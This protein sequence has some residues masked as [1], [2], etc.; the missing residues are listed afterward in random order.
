MT[1][2]AQDIDYAP[3]HDPLTPADIAQYAEK[4]EKPGNKL[5]KVVVWAVI[6]G[7]F[8][9]ISISLGGAIGSAS[10]PLVGVLASLGLFALT[11]ALAWFAYK[12]ETQ[13]I[14]NQRARSYKFALRNNAIYTPESTYIESQTGMIFDNGDKGPLTDIFQLTVKDVSVEIGNYVYSTGS[15]KSRREHR[16]GYMRL[17][18]QR[19]LPHMVLDSKANNLTAFGLTLSNGLGE[20]FKHDQVLS[21]EGD[22][23]NYFT[24]YCPK[25]YER[26]ALYVFTPDLMALLIDEAAS[27]D[28]EIVDNDMYVYQNQHFPVND[29]AAFRRLVQIAEVVGTKADDRTDYYAD[30]RVGDRSQDVVAIPGK[31]L[32]QSIPWITFIAI[33][34]YILWHFIALLGA[35][36]PSP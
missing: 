16:Y 1:H 14:T 5:V 23:N 22:F 32:K 26:D 34:L 18:L 21:L 11:A 30:E 3:L 17:T 13:K 7:I 8:G 28:V 29:E 36:N 6:F 20:R 35:G 15:G 24:L 2:T 4:F 27:F 9:F 31:R 25:Q 19:H 12:Y 10:S 33:A